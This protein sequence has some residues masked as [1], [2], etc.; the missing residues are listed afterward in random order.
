MTTELV[1]ESPK[2]I[3]SYLKQ[4]SVKNRLTEALGK[5]ANVEEFLSNVLVE[6]GKNEKLQACTFESVLQCAIDSANFGLIPN[7]Q[8]GHAY[9]IPYENSTK[10]GNKWFKK[11]ECQLQ[12]GYKGYIKKFAENGVTVDVE[13]VTK[14]EVL[15][16][17]FK[18][19]R[20]SNPYIFHEPIREGV[21]G[22]DDIALAYAIARRAGFADTIAVMGIDEILEVAKTEFYDQDLKTKVRELKGVWKDGKRDTDF[23]Q[24]CIKTAIRRLSKL[25]DIDVVTRMSSYEGEKEDY[26][27]KSLTIEGEVLKEP[28]QRRT[29]DDFNSALQKKKPTQET[30]VMDIPK[31]ADTA[32]PRTP[33]NEEV[34][35][36]EPHAAES[37]ALRI[38]GDISKSSK[39]KA[40]AIFDEEY[41]HIMMMPVEMQNRIADAL[42]K[43]Q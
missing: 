30:V 38:M 39:E 17:R 32:E 5:K 1:Q 14:R 29:A 10:V 22:R 12:I 40:Q 33:A 7:K 6:I 23:G 37:L 20:G 15:E 11:M 27:N 35:N 41:P 2:T 19:T 24:M 28:T 16:G 34:S 3:S 13:L 21:R 43:V 4:S 18:E 25:T 36:T 26:I 9:L 8:L 31:E 42:Q